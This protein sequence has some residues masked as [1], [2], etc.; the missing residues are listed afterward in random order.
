[1]KKLF[2]QEIYNNAKSWPFEEAKK[3]LQRPNF[4]LKNEII[5]ET[6][7]GPSGLPHIGTF[8]EVVRTTCVKHALQCLCDKKVR[9]FVFSDDRDGLRKV[10][11]NIPNKEMI[12]NYIGY[13]VTAIPDPFGC[14]ESFGHHNNAKLREFLDSF[15][16]EYEFQSATDW[17]N[18]GKLDSILLKILQCHNQILDVML[19]SLRQER[20]LTYSPF[21]PVCQKTGKI[22]QVP[23]EQYN[24]D[25][26]TIVFKNDQGKFVETEVIGGKCKL[27]WKAD[28]AA[29][30]ASI[31]V[32][33]EMS[34]K[35]LIDSVK[36]SSAICKILGGIPPCGF[37][38]ELFLDE[39]GKKVSKSKGNGLSVDDW[40]KYAPHES[41]ANFM[42]YSPKSAKKL[43]FD[44]IPRQVD[45][46]L[47]HLENYKSQ[48]DD[49][50]VDN[51]VWHIHSGVPPSYQ[52]PV[53]FSLLLN[54]VSVC[55]TDDPN[56]VWGFID[57]YIHGA[58]SK[59]FPYLDKL[60]LHAIM[61]YKDFIKPSK[62]YVLPNQQQKAAL[63]S[64]ASA[65]QKLEKST[66]SKL[67][68]ECV[69]EVGKQNG[70]TELK[71]WFDTLYTTLFGQKDGP[72]M[73]SF[74]SL[75]GIDNTIKLIQSK[76]E[77]VN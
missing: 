30:W 44:V 71:D 56:I 60:V 64:L 67:L 47:V 27:Q 23:I 24:V 62:H 45:D 75:Y 9:L 69:Y 39:N 63:S 52:S 43:Y 14:H 68:Q 17:Y 57:K 46:Y 2:L 20:A 41:L 65:L 48:T 18:S 37:N 51:P 74:I 32:D 50:R 1:M 31:G 8:G 33:Y 76:I 61:Y 25:A 55:N 66:D 34:G 26:G 42:F 29:R 5:F 49:K 59:K 58:N 13:P 77:I 3:I 19:P 70:F 4:S 15:G 35:D 12:A 6:G 7:Y 53:S 10:P 21:L 36:L 72:R 16:F 28:W 73:G 38:Y 54:L 11:D 40:L 22:L